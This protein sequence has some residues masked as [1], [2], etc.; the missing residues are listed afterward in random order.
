MAAH[1]IT[2]PSGK[3]LGAGYHAAGFYDEMLASPGQPRAAY[4]RVADVRYATAGS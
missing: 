3:P 2:V 4:R 1:T